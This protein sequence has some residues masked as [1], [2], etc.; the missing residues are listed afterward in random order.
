MDTSRKEEKKTK[1]RNAEEN[2]NEIR[3]KIVHRKSD[4]KTAT[5]I[6]KL[7][8]RRNCVEGHIENERKRNDIDRDTQNK[9]EIVQN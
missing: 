4:D 6:K 5:R 2:V 9:D 3:R 7:E 1:T 8:G